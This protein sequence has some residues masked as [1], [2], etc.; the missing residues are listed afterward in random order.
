MDFE[1]KVVRI[2]G[3]R[4]IVLPPDLLRWL[5]LGEGGEV[6]IRADEGKHGRFMSLWKKKST[7]K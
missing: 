5:G 4:G 3:S 6:I 7:K 2:G 1:R